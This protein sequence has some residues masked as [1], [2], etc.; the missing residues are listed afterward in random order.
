MTMRSNRTRRGFDSPRLHHTCGGAT[1]S[2]DGESSCET[3]GI[4]CHPTEQSVNGAEKTNDTNNL[5]TMPKRD[6]V[7]AM[8]FAFAA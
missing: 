6:A 4:L 1:V 5:V 2:I 7:P 3:T 8:D